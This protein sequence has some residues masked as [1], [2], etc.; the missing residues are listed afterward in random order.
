MNYTTAALA[1]LAVE[2]VRRSIAAILLAFT[3]PLAKVPGPMLMRF[4]GLFGAINAMRGEF[5]QNKASAFFK[6]Y[7]K[8][9]RVGML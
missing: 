8:V 5:D 2:L 9:V 6:K 4:T 7:G 3:G 1:I